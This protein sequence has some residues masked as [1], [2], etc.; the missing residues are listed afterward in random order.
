MG[1][2]A[3]ASA[4]PPLPGVGMMLAL[5]ALQHPSGSVRTAAQQWLVDASG[6]PQ[7]L[8]HPLL[9][10]LLSPSSTERVRLY[11]LAK[12]RAALSCMPAGTLALLAQQEAPEGARRGRGQ[13]EG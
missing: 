2:A 13:G 1:G 12:L 8:L 10:L 11:A 5:D 7:S 6:A 4:A 3:A 9:T